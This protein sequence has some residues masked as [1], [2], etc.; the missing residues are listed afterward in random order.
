MVEKAFANTAYSPCT[1]PAATVLRLLRARQH[2]A[3][4]LDPGEFAASEYS[5]D[6]NGASVKGVESAAA[7]SGSDAK[8]SAPVTTWAAQWKGD[9]GARQLSSMMWQPRS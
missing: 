5:E 8:A 1:K 2:H 6:A 4:V 3:L 7:A 9:R